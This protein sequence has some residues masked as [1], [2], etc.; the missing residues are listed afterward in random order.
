MTN[1]KSKVLEISRA[2]HQL[3]YKQQFHK[4][5]KIATIM[6][7]VVYFK[8]VLSL[9]SVLPGVWWISELVSTAIQIQ[10]GD[11]ETCYLRLALDVPNLLTVCWWQH[12]DILTSYPLPGGAGV[13]LQLAGVH[14]GDPGAALLRGEGGP[15][16]HHHHQDQHQPPPPPA[17]AAGRGVAV[18]DEER[19]GQTRIKDYDF[20]KF[21]KILTIDN[22]FF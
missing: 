3:S 10:H 5:I 11:N 20:Q 18:E 4:I 15:R 7:E 6:G 12:S 8:P 19:E 17:T 22:Y 13:L 1:G 2:E 21:V 14:H 16:P 9:T